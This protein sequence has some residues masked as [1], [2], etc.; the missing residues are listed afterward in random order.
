M[1]NM[2]TGHERSSSM[3]DSSD[4]E[5]RDFCS[6]DDD[7]D[8]RSDGMFDSIRTFASARVRALDTPVESMYDESPPSTAGN[9][10]TKRHSIQEVLA[11]TWD[12]ESKITEEEETTSTPVRAKSHL[13]LNI[14]STF[15]L[16]P[17]PNLVSKQ[18]EGRFSLDDD[19]DDDDWARSDD[20]E[21]PGNPL[22]PPSQGG[23]LNSGLIS[24]NIR[25]ALADI[26]GNGNTETTTRPIGESSNERPLSSI[27]DWSEP[28]AQDRQDVEGHSPRPKT[29]YAK[30]ELDTRSGRSALRKGPTPTHVRSQSVPVVH[31]TS[32]DAK[33]SGAKYGTWGLG[34]KTVSEDWDED[35]EFGGTGV[36][37]ED[38]SDE[39]LF[40][41][42]EAIRATQPSVKAHSG[43]IR[44]LSLLV[45]DLKRLC[46]HARDFDMLEG[47]Q[48][49]LW[50]EAEGI[51]ALASPDE[52][53]DDALADHLSSSSIDLD[54]FE[55]DDRFVD[56]GFGTDALDGRRLADE[57]PISTPSK[58]AVPTQR[59]V[60]SPEDDI[61]G[62]AGSPSSAELAP[63]VDG[64]SRPRTPHNRSPKTYTHDVNGVVQSMVVAM[65]HRSEPDAWR[66][67]GHR[68]NRMHFDTN[69]LKVLVKRAGDLRDLLSDMIRQADQITQSP[70]RTPRP[71]RHLESSPAFTRVFDDPGS[72]PPRRM[73]ASRGRPSMMESTTPENSPSS[74]INRSMQAMTVG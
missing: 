29:A 43:Q 10:R 74:A 68:S 4:A 12:G 6:G 3:M 9:G 36:D 44:E 7:T 71:E 58:N 2:R 56:A 70:V 33:P 22:S 55:V 37:L 13:D 30:Q 60:F 51:I 67:T 57:V 41:V 72:S 66:E 11:R 63:P 50:K 8:F 17:A 38:K 25:L 47:A 46:R 54:A 21:T 64:P 34:T 49:G 26:S 69:S 1:S 62:G 18:D 52:D 20:D 23:S 45:N 53:E 61:F 28:S 42:P 14:P 32:E 59:A 31:E 15:Q 27:F 35:F 73:V 65:Q 24:P 16:Q 48:R 19:F 39:R 5:T 40:A